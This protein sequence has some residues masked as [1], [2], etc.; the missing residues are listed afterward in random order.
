MLNYVT[1]VHGFILERYG[2][3]C[4][5]WYARRAQITF[6]EEKSSYENQTTRHKRWLLNGIFP[7]IQPKIRNCQKS[8]WPSDAK[9]HNVFVGKAWEKM[10]IDKENRSCYVSLK[11]LVN[12]FLPFSSW[13]ITVLIEAECPRGEESRVTLRARRNSQIYFSS[14]I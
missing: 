14:R 12:C 9:G 7:L 5:G 1:I 8:T 13:K 2:Y 10:V 6:D 11:D 3:K 4:L